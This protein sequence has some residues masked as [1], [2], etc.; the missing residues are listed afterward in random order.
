VL[1]KAQVQYIT[2]TSEHFV[3]H[4][5]P[6]EQ[7]NL[8]QALRWAER[9]LR[10]CEA[11]FPW[12]VRVLQQGR[13]PNEWAFFVAK[14]TYQQILKAH[15]EKVQDLQWK[16]EHTATSAVGDT[17]L[18]ATSGKQVLFDAAVRNVARPYAGFSTD[19]LG[20]GIGHTFVGMMF[21]NNRL[22][23]VDLKK[24]QGTVASEED[25]EYQSPDFDV[26]KTLTSS[27]RGSTPAACRRATC[28]SATRRRSPTSSASRRG[29]SATT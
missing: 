1:D 28:R 3:L 16:L 18:A 26:W 4:G 9:T 15:A 8:G 24:Q 5:D 29:R 25:R 19:G 20:E 14:E 17:L 2:L 11:A 13:W 7:E 12:P 21:N 22:F 6:E 27:W 10:V 23:A